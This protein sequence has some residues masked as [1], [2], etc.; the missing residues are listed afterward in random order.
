MAEYTVTRQSLPA[1]DDG[2]NRWNLRAASLVRFL[3]RRGRP[4]QVLLKEAPMAPKARGRSATSLT[5]YL[6]KYI[7]PCLSLCPLNVELTV[8]TIL[9]R[10][11]RLPTWNS[12]SHI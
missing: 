5:T 1:I 3:R 10:C 12:W 6:L 7:F 2:N 8:Q 9:N 4:T 11:A